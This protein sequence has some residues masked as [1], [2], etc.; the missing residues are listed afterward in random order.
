MDSVDE[1]E[2]ISQ[3]SKLENDLEVASE[4]LDALVQGGEGIGG[5]KGEGGREE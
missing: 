5:G 4:R 2:R 3:R 1:E